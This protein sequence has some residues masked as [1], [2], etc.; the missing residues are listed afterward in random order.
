M[1]FTQQQGQEYGFIEN[2]LPRKNLLTRPAVAN[3]DILL[4]VVSAGKPHIDYMLCDKLLI[5]AEYSGIAPV[6]CVNKAEM[7]KKTA[8]DIENQYVAY[9]VLR[10]SAHKGEGIRELEELICGKCVCFT[11]Q[12]AVGKSSL[13]NVIDKERELETGELSKKTARGKHTTR[14]TELLH[15]PKLNAY[16]LDTPGFSMLDLQDVAWEELPYYYREFRPYSEECRFGGC[17]HDKEPDCMVKKALEKGKIDKRRYER[18]L[19]LKEEM[20]DRENDSW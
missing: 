9:D 14:T 18:Y 6:L 11:G 15:L 10:V 17:M 12:S 16:V 7:D 13:I 1:E 2:I 4:V 3:I 19:R 20:K 5:Q 8:A